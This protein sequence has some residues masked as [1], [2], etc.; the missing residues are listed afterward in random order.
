MRIGI[1]G[2]W[3]GTRGDIIEDENRLIAETLSEMGHE[4]TPLPG[5][6]G[7]LNQAAGFMKKANPARIALEAFVGARLERQLFPYDSVIVNGR[8][9]NCGAVARAMGSRPVLV[10]GRGGGTPEDCASLSNTTYVCE[11]KEHMKRTKK[12][13]RRAV[14]IERS[15]R[16]N[17]SALKRR[18]EQVIEDQV[19]AS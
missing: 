18:L 1:A 6:D 3:R 5:L 14:L 13:G 9:V 17:K 8:N 11:C 12:N 7:I 4:V 19:N 2:P 15:A 10:W 16:G